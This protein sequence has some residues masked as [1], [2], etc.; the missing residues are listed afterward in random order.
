M[1]D[2]VIYHYC[3]TETFLKI[4][5]SNSIFLSHC[6]MLN[7]GKE[8]R[9]FL[10]SIKEEVLKDLFKDKEYKIAKNIIKNYKE[11]L[12]FPYVACFSKNKDL[13]NQWIAYGDNG[14]G[15]CLGV[16]LSKIPFI[17]LLNIKHGENPILMIDEMSYSDDDQ[18]LIEKI[19][20][21]AII[22]YNKDGNKKRA[23]ENATIMLENL[24]IFT[25]STYF[26]N[27][28]EIRMVYRPC[29]REMLQNLNDDKEKSGN[30]LEMGFLATKTKIR[31]YFKYN[32][33]PDA[34]STVVLGPKNQIEFN[35]L[36]M[37]LSKYAP[38]VRVEN[39]IE[40]SKISYQDF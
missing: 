4:I 17:D 23:I 16:D 9:I 8:D 14:N 38:R 34:I 7:D 24:S 5:M 19:I 20:K 31:S 27:E 25:K 13:L 18:E 32:L 2:D 33:P 10:D 29:Y 11:K 35:Q 22:N 30:N 3:S 39:R 15:V 40:H 1:I 26:K 37:L 36:T 6:R 12:D 28:E 21:A